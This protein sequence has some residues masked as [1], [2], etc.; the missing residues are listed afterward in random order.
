VNTA[1]AI[2]ALHN[3]ISDYAEALAKHTEALT[4]L[5]QRLGEFTKREQPL[6]RDDSEIKRNQ[7]TTRVWK[8]MVQVQ[9]EG[10][11]PDFK[12]SSIRSIPQREWMYQPNFGRKSLAELV[13]CAATGERNR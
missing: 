2:S 3:A 7:V 6:K 10:R 12:P 8:I 5:A 4:E 1:H 11:I 9:Q 13:T